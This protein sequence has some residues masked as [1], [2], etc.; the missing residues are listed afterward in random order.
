M[1]AFIFAAGLGTR[2]KPLTDTMPKALVP[3]ADKPLLQHVLDKLQAEGFDKFVVNIHHF[4]E[5]IISHLRSYIA[6]GRVV[7]SDERAALLE[8][9]GAI[10]KAIP[11][12]G[13]DSFLIHNV[14]ILSNART[15]HLMQQHTKMQAAATL[16]VSK[17]Q[18]S[19][20]LL[21][22]ADMRLKA[23]TNTLTGEVKTPYPNLDISQL[24][25]MAFSGI[26]CFSPVLFDATK[27]YPDKFSIIDFYLDQCLSFPIY[28]Y[29]QKDL[30]LLDVGKIDS[31]EKANDFIELS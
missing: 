24:T 4:G 19:R 5:Q 6:E 16:L 20:M 13:N 15:A 26:H 12:L 30:K 11:L 1:K 17:R 21:F 31:L 25:P 7:I 3:V 18:S 28:G 27:N 8:T 10:K 2:L 22:D 9:G 23:W 29:V 14:D